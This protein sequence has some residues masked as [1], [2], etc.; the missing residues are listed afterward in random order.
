MNALFALAGAVLAICL[1]FNSTP[2]AEPHGGD[3]ASLAAAAPV[4]LLNEDCLVG[5]PYPG[6]TGGASAPVITDD[7]STVGSNNAGC[8]GCL[9]N[10]KL[11]ITWHYTGLGRWKIN[12]VESSTGVVPGQITYVRATLTLDC[13]VASSGLQVWANTEYAEWLWSCGACK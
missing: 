7:G 3:M 11:K 2:A 9:V 4:T 12:G 6:G 1:G 13:G 8:D 5:G 10:A